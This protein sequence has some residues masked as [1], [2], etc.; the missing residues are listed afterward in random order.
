MSSSEFAS[1]FGEFLKHSDVRGGLLQK[2]YE[3]LH[4]RSFLYLVS[5]RRLYNLQNS[6]ESPSFFPSG[7]LGGRSPSVILFITITAKS[8]ALSSA[9]GTRPVNT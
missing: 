7:G 5:P 1:K 9:N 2:L 6:S 4:R 8:Y 3:R